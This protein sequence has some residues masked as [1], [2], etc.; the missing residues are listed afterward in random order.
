SHAIIIPLTNFYP[1][2]SFSYALGSSPNFVI[3]GG[4]GLFHGT[5][6][7]PLL[8]CQIPS[9]GGLQK[10]PGRENIQDDLNA[11]T[12]LSAFGADPFT[13]AVSLAAMV[14][15]NLPVASYPSPSLDAVIVR[16]VNNHKPPY[17]AQASFGVEFQPFKDAVLDITGM[18]VRGIHL[19]SFWN[20]NQPDP[21]PACNDAAH[22]VHDSRGR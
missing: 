19:G 1:R 6:P 20:V 5:I 14:G 15:P 7:S 8:M 10:Y 3:R 11:K 13:M 12:R 2:A 9:C 22:V 18:H 16:F 17:G 21:N 4:A